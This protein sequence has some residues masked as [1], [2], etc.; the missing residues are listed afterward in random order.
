M[1]YF[2]PMTTRATWNKL[3]RNSSKQ[4][5]QDYCEGRTNSLE[6]IIFD[7]KLLDLAPHRLWRIFRKVWAN[8]EYFKEFKGSQRRRF[9]T[10]MAALKE[11][12]LISEDA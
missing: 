2:Y 9:R 5:V 11:A 6:E 7:Y 12:G 10:L 8:R 3:I 4:H 1:L